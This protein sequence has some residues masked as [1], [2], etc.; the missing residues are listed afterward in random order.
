MK[1]AYGII[2]KE[3]TKAKYIILKKRV[4][5]MKLTLKKSTFLV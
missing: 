4:Y 5:V 3:V 2:L 1:F